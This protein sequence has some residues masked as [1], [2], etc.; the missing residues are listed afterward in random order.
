MPDSASTPVEW[1]IEDGAIVV[2][3]GNSNYPTVETIPLADIT[4]TRITRMVRWPTDALL[5][6]AIGAVSIV[7]SLIF[8]TESGPMAFATGLVL[9]AIGLFMRWRSKAVYQLIAA[10]R[11]TETVVAQSTVKARIHAASISLDQLRGKGQ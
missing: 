5:C 7:L 11:G 6:I 8:A 3:G 10:H 9:V 2:H 1:P 4:A